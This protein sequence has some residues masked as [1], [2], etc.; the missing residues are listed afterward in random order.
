[1]LLLLVMVVGG[2]LSVMGRRAIV[3][4]G[5]FHMLMLRQTHKSTQV[6]L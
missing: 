3:V 1:M 5:P 6:S 2:D 4:D